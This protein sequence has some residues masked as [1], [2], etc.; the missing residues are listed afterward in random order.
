[1]TTTASSTTAAS[2]P[3]QTGI[4]KVSRGPNGKPSSPNPFGSPTPPPGSG[5]TACRTSTAGQTAVPARGQICGWQLLEN[6]LHPRGVVGNFP[7]LVMMR[8]FGTPEQMDEFIRGRVEGKEYCISQAASSLGAAVYCVEQSVE[9]A[10]KQAS[11]GKPLSH[12]QGIQ[13][14]LV[15]LAIQC[16]MLRLLI[17]KTALQMDSMSHREVEKRLGDEISM[18]NYWANRL[19][20][21]A[22]DRAIQVHGGLRCGRE[23]PFEHI[24]R[25]H[26][27]YR[28]T[29]GSE[30]IQMRNVAAH[31]FEFGGRR[32]E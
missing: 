17:R 6:I 12:N 27:K 24:W 22:A 19:C 18:C 16:E 14:P 23:L 28:N 26:R 3:A 1:M 2:T 15:E 30:E 13:F 25:H 20:C 9:Y 31:L 4:T 5:P 21:E 11:F 8:E 7:D 29:E 10:N 32:S